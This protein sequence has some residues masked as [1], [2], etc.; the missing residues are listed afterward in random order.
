MRPR[1]FYFHVYCDC[2]DAV[3]ALPAL[4]LAVFEA[5]HIKK[6]TGFQQDAV[7]G[8]G[9]SAS[10]GCAQPDKS[11]IMNWA[12]NEVTPL[13]TVHIDTKTAETF[14]ACKRQASWVQ[15]DDRARTHTD[16]PQ[17]P[18]LTQAIHPTVPHAS[19]QRTPTTAASTHLSTPNVADVAATL[20][21]RGCTARTVKWKL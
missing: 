14:R 21:H 20:L 15:L 12:R 17:P 9:L 5:H 2:C 4:L 19:M 3:L 16:H 6:E 1:Q 11:R 18:A 7:F 8:H 13:T 10:S